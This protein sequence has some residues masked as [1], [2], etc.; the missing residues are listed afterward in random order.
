METHK[1]GFGYHQNPMC[2]LC[3]TSLINH[4]IKIKNCASNFNLHV[5]LGRF[6]HSDFHFP[7]KNSGTVLEFPEKD[8]DLYLFFKK[9]K[10]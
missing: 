1:K 3:P 7:A 2:F 10:K 6:L 5:I 9:P 4:Y 8:K